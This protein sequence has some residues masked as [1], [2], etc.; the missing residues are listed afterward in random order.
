VAAGVLDRRD[1]FCDHRQLGGLAE[2]RHTAL[3]LPLEVALQRRGQRLEDV[4]DEKEDRAGEQQ[5][6]QDHHRAE[7]DLDAQARQNFAA[8]G[9]RRECRL[10]GLD[11]LIGMQ[12]VHVIAAGILRTQLPGVEA[13]ITEFAGPRPWTRMCS[14]VR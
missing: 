14:L 7:R 8:I 1:L 3:G 13:R 6:D 10:R 2:L 11:G 5:D 9:G 12:M 4:V